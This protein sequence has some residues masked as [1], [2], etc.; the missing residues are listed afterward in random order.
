MVLALVLDSGAL[1]AEVDA[2]SVVSMP[3]VVC[4]VPVLATTGATDGDADGPDDTG[5][6]DVVDCAERGALDGRQDGAVDVGGAETGELDGAVDGDADTGATVGALVGD[7]DGEAVVGG[8]VLGLQTRS[9]A[10]VHVAISISPSGHPGEQSAARSACHVRFTRVEARMPKENRIAVRR[11]GAY[12]P[13]TSVQTER[14]R[15]RKNSA[16]NRNGL[17]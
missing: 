4:A 16:H 1:N 5:A 9:D 17:S 14:E 6:R 11:Y 10:A 13:F 7:A 12:G 8:C 2:R 15:A 3:S